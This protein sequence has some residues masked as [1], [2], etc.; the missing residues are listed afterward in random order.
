MGE[1][2]EEKMKERLKR[3]LDAPNEEPFTIDKDHDLPR[4]DDTPS[5]PC[6]EQEQRE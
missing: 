2:R 3:L 5:R 6:D 1:E 4:Y